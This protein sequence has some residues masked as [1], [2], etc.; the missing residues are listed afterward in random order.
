MEHRKMITAKA[1]LSNL[2][3]TIQ[4]VTPEDVQLKL[5][6]GAR[7]I[8]VREADEFKQGH[9][10]GAIF[11]PRGFLELRIEDAVPDREQELILYCA[12]G[13]R[14][15]FAA[16]NLHELGYKNVRSMSGGF[17]KWKDH[18]YPIEVPEVLN[19][20]Q[21][22]RYQ[23]HLII[24]EIGEKGQLKLLKSKVLLIGAGGLGCPS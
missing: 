9:L 12:G 24:P 20:A 8:D 7:I 19:D 11:I 3:G 13:S 22:K 5:N 6:N 21:R 14:S 15:I 2:R 1:F 18:G 17:Q 16:H 4:E 23:R 10:P